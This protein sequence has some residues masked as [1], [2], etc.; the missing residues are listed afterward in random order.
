MEI[1]DAHCHIASEEHFPR[2]FIMGA[3]DNMASALHAQNIPVAPQK[4]LDMYLQKLQDPLCDALVAEMDAAGISKSVLLIPDFTIALKDS[5]LSIEESFLKH[6]EVLARHPG[7]FEVFGGVDPRWGDDGVRLFER[8]LVEF[9]FRGF[10]LYPPCGYSPSDPALFPF[11]DLCAQH[12]VPVLLHI[13]PTSPALAFDTC[14]P[15]LIDEAARRFPTVPFILAHGAVS[16]VEECTMLCRFR[17]NVY[18][19]VSG[20]QMTLAWDGDANAVRR[21]VSQDITHKVLFGTDW[22]VFRMQGT[23]SSFVER[24]TGDTGALSDLTDAAMALVLH[25]NIQRLLRGKAGA[26]DPAARTG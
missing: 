16:F 21:L 26:A 11:Y 25:G 14:N 22:P 17:P 19:D 15:F 18:L 10:K 4:L 13:G 20:F 23:Q 12:G 24:L 7:R 6:R 9:G 1:I 5:R 3:I 2:S 8:S